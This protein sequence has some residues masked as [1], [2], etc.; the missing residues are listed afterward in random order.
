VW[1]TPGRNQ[2]GAAKIGVKFNKWEFLKLLLR[3]LN[4]DL[5]LSVFKEKGS[6]STALLL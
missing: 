5:L 3:V 2:E 6:L 4:T 1:T